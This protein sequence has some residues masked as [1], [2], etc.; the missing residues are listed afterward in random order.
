MYTLER[1]IY[2]AIAASKGPLLLDGIIKQITGTKHTSRVLMVLRRLEQK[3]L[4]R[5]GPDGWTNVTTPAPS[6]DS[7][8][9]E[10]DQVLDD[11]RPSRRSRRRRQHA[12]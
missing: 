7:Q 2:D 8:Q 5:L 12:A 4:V 1:E 6:N 10:L 3:D 11:P 9:D